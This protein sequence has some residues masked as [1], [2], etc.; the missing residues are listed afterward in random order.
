VAFDQPGRPGEF[1][2][3]LTLAAPDGVV[4]K[5][6]FV[7]SSTSVTGTILDGGTTLELDFSPHTFTQGDTLDYSIGVCR[8]GELKGCVMGR[9]DELLEGGTYTYVFETDNA[10]GTPV[11]LFLTT[12][13]L[14]GIGGGIEDLMS[15]SREPDLTIPSQILNP[16]TFVGFGILPCTPIAGSCPPLVLA[17]ADPVEDNPVVPEP[18]SILIL[19][20]ALAV[21]PFAYRYSSPARLSS[22]EAGLAEPL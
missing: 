14:V 7:A 21:L 15:N 13:D 11:E 5:G 18:P 6:P 8:T 10:T 16:D 20:A 1:L 2:S 19:L 17:D 12:S 9:P 3:K 22:L 4:F